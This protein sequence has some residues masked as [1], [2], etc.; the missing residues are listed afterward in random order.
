MSKNSN[1]DDEKDFSTAQLSK[2]ENSNEMAFLLSTGKGKSL[3]KNKPHLITKFSKQSSF[4]QV[5][6]SPNSKEN[7]QMKE[8]SQNQT[9]R[10]S[11]P[12][13]SSSKQSFREDN[14][15]QSQKHKKTKDLSVDSE[16][17]NEK[18]ENLGTPLPT[19]RT[20]NYKKI[21]DSGSVQPLNK[22]FETLETNASSFSV[23]MTSTG[24][25]KKKKKRRKKKKKSMKLQMFQHKTPTTPQNLTI[26][27][28]VRANLGS[29]LLQL[30]GQ[31]DKIK[32]KKRST[33]REDRKVKMEVNIV[34]SERIKTERFEDDYNI[35]RLA[36]FSLNAEMLE[37][38]RTFA[39]PMIGRDST[40]EGFG[41][42][43]AVETPQEIRKFELSVGMKLTE[44]K[45][46]G[47][48]RKV[49]TLFGKKKKK[50]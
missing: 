9:T 8:V 3:F 35:P 10:Q 19:I 6:I 42:I 44:K 1:G 38:G 29:D 4:T 24:K 30:S 15:T 48:F 7:E 23:E 26:T 12:A 47:K 31:K 13:V 46:K 2:L 41:E 34:G 27:P 36:M 49:P 45:K 32:P 22:S 43:E 14:K 37:S 21:Q 5:N 16:N 39:P 20:V 25:K 50:N 28:P 11:Y 17:K 18:D 40:E 33:F